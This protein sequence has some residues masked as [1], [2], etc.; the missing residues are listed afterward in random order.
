VSTRFLKV[1]RQ[2]RVFLSGSRFSRVLPLFAIGRTARAGST[3]SPRPQTAAIF[4][5]SHE[6]N[7]GTASGANPEIDSEAGRGHG[8][9]SI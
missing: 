8:L 2:G 9:C 7:A 5:H 4:P 6:A 1:F 3:G